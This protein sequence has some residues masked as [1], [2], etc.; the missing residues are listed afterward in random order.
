MSS[1]FIPVQSEEE[2]K[3]YYDAGLLYFNHSMVLPRGPEWKPE[4]DEWHEVLGDYRCSLNDTDLSETSILPKD[5]GYLVE[6]DSPNEEDE[7]DK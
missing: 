5:W 7:D 3:R 1:R 4:T 2:L 6:D